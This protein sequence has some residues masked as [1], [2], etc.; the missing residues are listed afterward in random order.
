[1]ILLYGRELVSA[2][3]W[4]LLAFLARRKVLTGDW[5]GIAT[6]CLNYVAQAGGIWHLWGHSW[7]IERHNAWS[8]L[9]GLFKTI[10]E[11]AGTHNLSLVDNSQLMLDAHADE[12]SNLE[13]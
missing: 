5:V 13:R 11:T 7:D 12:S 6:R 8:K 10:E 1:V 3:N 9:D 4:K 2:K